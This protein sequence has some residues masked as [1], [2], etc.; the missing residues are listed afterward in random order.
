MNDLELQVK[1]L[2]DKWSRRG[3]HPIVDTNIFLTVQEEMHVNKIFLE[4]Q[5]PQ[6]L[7]EQTSLVTLM[8]RTVDKGTQPS[9]EFLH[10]TVN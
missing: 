7:R 3:R 2:E 9:R 1:N 8:E 6:E 5:L 4:T 10:K